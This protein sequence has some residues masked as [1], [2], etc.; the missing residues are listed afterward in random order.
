MKVESIDITLHVVSLERTMEWYK[1]IL[2]WKSG[3]D[4][5]NKQGECIYDSFKRQSEYVIKFTKDEQDRTKIEV[6]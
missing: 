2:G 3:C 1:R 5:K 6:L 4:L